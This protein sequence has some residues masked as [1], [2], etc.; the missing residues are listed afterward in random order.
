[1][2][3]TIGYI[4]LG[5]MGRPMALNLLKAGYVVHVWARRAEAMEPLV[6][7]GARGARSLPE[8]A[9]EADVVFLNVS[10]TTDVEAL[11]LG[12]GGLVEYLRPGSIVVDH[13]TIDPGATRHIA[14]R[15][16]EAG[17]EMLDAPV[18]G[19]EAGAIAG[20]LS[21]MVGGSEAALER[22]HRLLQVV[23][24][25]IVHIGAAGAGQ[26]CK[27]CNQIVVAQAMVAIAEAFVLCE[28]S[29]VDAARVREA[30]LG[31]FASSRILEVHGQ[32]MLDNDYAPGFKAL[33]HQK[34]L[35]IALN[36]AAQAGVALPGA[37][38]AA[39]WVNALVGSGGGELD[40]SAIAQVLR[41]LNGFDE[42]R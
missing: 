10:D 12:D 2:A 13:S 11:A 18:S 40:S 29:G 36:A 32:R 24:E 28:S 39:Q 30:L 38:Q 20:S 14:S 8:L 37:A 17:I 1:M 42:I 22:V 26:L 7:A 41:R 35:G 31:G 27:A 34:D 16:A 3:L 21:I 23:G 15:L 6:S 19:G 25:R 9:R 33:L 4:G 5:I